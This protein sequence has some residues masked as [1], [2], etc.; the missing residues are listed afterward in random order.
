MYQVFKINKTD[1]QFDCPCDAFFEVFLVGNVPMGSLFAIDH[2]LVW[3]GHKG[4][5]YYIVFV[6][7]CIVVIVTQE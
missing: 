7:H 5:N 3:W 6:M 1:V 2:V 4:K